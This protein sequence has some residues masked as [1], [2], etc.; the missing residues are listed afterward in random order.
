MK[1]YKTSRYPEGYMPKIEYYQ[2]KL[3]IAV[4]T[5]SLKDIKFFTT[6]LEYFMV[7]EEARQARLAELID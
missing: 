1:D 5:L 7:R 6:K 4:S 3:S 2:A